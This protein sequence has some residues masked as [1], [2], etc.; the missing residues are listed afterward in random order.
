MGD[1]KICPITRLHDST[2]STTT[3]PVVMRTLI[4]PVASQ[5]TPH[6]HMYVCSMEHNVAFACFTFDATVSIKSKAYLAHH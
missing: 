3:S 2:A 1:A 6:A 5:E 4:M